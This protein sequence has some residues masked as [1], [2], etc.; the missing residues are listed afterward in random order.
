M[1][2]RGELK[3][4]VVEIGIQSIMHNLTENASKI[5]MPLR[6]GV[7]CNTP[8]ASMLFPTI[9]LF[10]HSSYTSV[11]CRVYFQTQQIWLLKK[12]LFRKEVKKVF[13]KTMHLDRKEMVI[14]FVLP[15]LFYIFL[16]FGGRS[17]FLQSSTLLLFPSFFV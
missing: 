3:V 2:P 15:N 8:Q 17:F 14:F 13:N 16:P 11:L 9:F 5:I 4:S 1:K 10:L 6:I 7:T 12:D